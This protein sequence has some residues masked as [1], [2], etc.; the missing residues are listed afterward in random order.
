MRVGLLAYWPGIGLEADL[1][2][3]VQRF[4]R[5][6]ADGF[7]SAWAVNIFT[8]DALTLLALAG[9]ATE[10]L[11][12]GTAVVPTYPRHP[13]ALAQQAL[14][15]QA[16]GGNRLTLGIGLSHKRVIEDRLGL[17]YAKPVRH[18]REYLTVLRRL[19]AGESTTFQGQEYRVQAQLTVPGT[20]PPPI[21]VA[22]LGPQLLRL[23]GELA[24]GTIVAFGGPRYLATT[25]V[26]RITQAARAAGRPAPRVAAMFPVAVT[27]QPAAARAAAAATFGGY[28]TVPSYRRN[29]DI[30][31]AA[32]V[33]AVTI[34]GT[35][36]EV[37]AQ[38]RHLAAVGVT[39]LLIT[40]FPVPDVPGTVERTY[41]FV[42]TLARSATA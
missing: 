2:E 11:E 7:A 1:R 3:L 37:G 41:E 19:L 4:A 27:D 35:E 30:E 23:A 9:P 21:L 31:G 8:F 29:L 6:E 38:V 39:D 36:D 28:G 16:A 13:V 42:G 22:A 14:T 24:D 32:D 18:M 17:S 25:A 40:P 10:R 33:T 20:T 34:I 12:L 15:T 26:P 5:A